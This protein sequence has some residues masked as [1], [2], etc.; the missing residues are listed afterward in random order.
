MCSDACVSG[1]LCSEG[2][3]DLFRWGVLGGVR[4]Q[5]YQSHLNYVMLGSA[6]RGTNV[7]VFVRKDLV[8]GVGLV[9]TTARVVVVGVAGCQ[10]GG[11]YRKCGVGV[12]EMRDWL[13]S[14]EG[15]VGGG[16]WVLLG[17]WKANH[18]PWSLDG[19]SG[20]GAGFCRSG[21]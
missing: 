3:R 5:W 1:K 7:V 17:D 12:H 18:D 9:A 8:D 11:V 6:S 4:W 20:P 15:W 16:E 10:I 13:G 2:G 14:W 21:S 19:R